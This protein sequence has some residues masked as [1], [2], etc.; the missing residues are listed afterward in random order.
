MSGVVSHFPWG[1]N[2]SSH[3]HHAARRI[4]HLLRWHWSHCWFC[5]PGFCSFQADDPV[6]AADAARSCAGWIK[7]RGLASSFLPARK[8]HL[9]VGTCV[10]LRPMIIHLCRVHLD[11]QQIEKK[12]IIIIT[13]KININLRSHILS[14]F[15]S[16]PSHSL[17]GKFYFK[18]YSVL[19]PASGNGDEETK[20]H[21]L[22]VN[23]AISWP[24][25]CSRFRSRLQV[26]CGS[27]QRPSRSHG[28]E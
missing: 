23:P 28:Q 4:S 27:H 18:I 2:V 25:P 14:G 3:S 21:D 20:M 9:L 15:G 1:Q 12:K 5:I 22:R 19:Y 10:S 26:S 7:V 13:I 16:L 24:W 17:H 8:L 6:S 11:K